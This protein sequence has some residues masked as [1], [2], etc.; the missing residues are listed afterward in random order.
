VAVLVEDLDLDEEELPGEGGDAAR[1]VVEVAASLLGANA[2]EGA[3]LRVPLGEVGEPDWEAA[4]RDR[5]LEAELDQASPDARPASGGEDGG[6]G[7][8]PR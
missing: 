1:M 3:V 6:G 2:V 5:E 7:Q 4:E 8:N